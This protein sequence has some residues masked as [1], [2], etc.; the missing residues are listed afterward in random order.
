MVFKRRDKPPLAA[1]VI[2]FLLPRRGWRRGIEYIAHRLR[3]LPD[4]PHRIALGFSC[5]VLAS[6]TPFFGF[7]LIG[8]VALA[9]LIR[10]NLI[11]AAI[12]QF[13]GNP[14]TLPFIAWISMA[15]GRRILGAGA[16]GRDFERVSE[17]LWSAAAGLWQ[18][19]LSLLGMGEPQWSRVAVVVTDVILPY[20][21][22]GL[23]PG[24]VT[25]IAFYYLVRPIVAAYQAARRHRRLVRA[26]ARLAA[27]RARSHRSGDPGSGNAPE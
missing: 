1:R 5:G 8:A 14:F 24:I 23:L 10:A 11:A 15:L 26:E 18:S 19:L 7:H 4:T 13:V 22:G 2:E 27:Q 6:W 20:F 3:R 25:A 16:T 21:I 12:G 9:W 17:A